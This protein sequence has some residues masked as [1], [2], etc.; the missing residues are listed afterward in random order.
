MHLRSK[1]KQI[2]VRENVG[3]MNV[4]DQESLG[5]FT[6]SFFSFFTMALVATKKK[7]SIE[8]QHRTIL[9]IM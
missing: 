8:E 7:R 2:D 5:D 9:L 3:W 6:F 1:E 4:R